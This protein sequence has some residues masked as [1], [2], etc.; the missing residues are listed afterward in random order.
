MKRFQALD[1]DHQGRLTTALLEALSPAA[2][3]EKK[4]DA[5]VDEDPSA[6]PPQ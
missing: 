4:Q 6:L 3:L 2:P 5:P 1:V